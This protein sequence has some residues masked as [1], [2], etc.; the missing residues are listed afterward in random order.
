MF[1]SSHPD[2]PINARHC[3]A[4]T[5]FSFF[6]RAVRPARARVKKEK[7]SSA[8]GGGGVDGLRPPLIDDHVSNHHFPLRLQSGTGFSWLNHPYR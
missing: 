8:S 1:E 7:P 5:G 6:D 3:E 2:Q 4:V